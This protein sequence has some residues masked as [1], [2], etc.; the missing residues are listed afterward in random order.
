MYATD[1]NLAALAALEEE[2]VKKRLDKYRVPAL[3]SL[4]TEKPEGYFRLMGAQVNGLSSKMA[5]A[6]KVLQLTELLV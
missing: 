3:D 2:Q 6:V 5:R 1:P 4:L